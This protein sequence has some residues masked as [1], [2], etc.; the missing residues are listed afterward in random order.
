MSLIPTSIP[1]T[2]SQRYIPHQQ[3]IN[4]YLKRGQFQTTS[5]A[6]FTNSLHLSYKGISIFFEV[7]RHALRRYVK[8]IATLVSAQRRVKTGHFQYIFINDLLFCINSQQKLSNMML[9]NLLEIPE[10]IRTSNL[11]YIHLLVTL[12]T[13]RHGENMSFS[14]QELLHAQHISLN[15]HIWGSMWHM[16]KNKN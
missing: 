10:K 12:L 9:D 16:T 3:E 11:I 8:Q 4:N 6:W 13:P 2:V 7:Q 1:L 14:L 15:I 5:Y